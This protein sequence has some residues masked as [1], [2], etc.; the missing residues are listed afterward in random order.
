MQRTLASFLLIAVVFSTMG[1]GR[2]K[3]TVSVPDDSKLRASPAQSESKTT[4]PAS[5]SSAASTAD[6]TEQNKQQTQPETQKQTEPQAQPKSDQTAGQPA[7][8]QSAANQPVEGSAVPQT[9]T[10]GSSVENKPVQQTAPKSNGNVISFGEFFD[11]D[12]RTTPSN[13]FWDLKGQQVEI[14][15]YMGEVLSLEKHWF[16]LIPA[17]GAECPFDS[18]NGQLWNEIM[19]VFVKDGDKL[20]YTRGPLKVKGTLD[21]GIKVDQSGY[22]TMFRLQNASFETM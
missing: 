8:N 2:E 20:R 10:T 22:R 12:N 4:D 16:L 15:G 7:A 11:G 5:Q 3:V 21:V 13:K 14:K 6:V 17:P 18:G 1:C 19:I 9:N